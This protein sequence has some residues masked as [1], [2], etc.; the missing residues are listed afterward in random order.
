MQVTSMRSSHQTV[1]YSWLIGTIFSLV[2][3]P[4]ALPRHGPSSSFFILN[5]C[6]AHTAT[7]LQLRTKPAEPRPPYYRPTKPTSPPYLSRTFTFPV[8][9]HWI[10]L[11]ANYSST[12]TPRYDNTQT[13]EHANEPTPAAIK[14]GKGSPTST[15]NITISLDMQEDPEQQRAIVYLHGWRLHVL[16]VAC[17]NPQNSTRG[18]TDIS[19]SLCLS[20]FLSTIETTIVSTALVAITNALNGFVKSNWIVTSYLLTYAGRHSVKYK[21]CE[22]ANCMT[23]FLIILSRFSDIFGRKPLI[24]LAVFLFTVFSAACGAAQNFTQL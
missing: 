21:M 5:C 16:T 15:E 8:T 20:L 6:K 11:M 13:D 12:P 2:P 9:H 19:A 17:V 23:G 4:L 1:Y 18:I 14:D 7:I 22:T 10:A 24:I 3:T